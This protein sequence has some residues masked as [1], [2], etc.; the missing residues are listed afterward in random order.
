[1]HKGG[2]LVWMIAVDRLRCLRDGHDYLAVA[3][4]PIEWCPRCGKARSLSLSAS[5]R[6]RNELDEQALQLAT[7]A[8]AQAR[9]ATRVVA[10]TTQRS[11]SWWLT[12]QRRA[13]RERAALLPGNGRAIPTDPS[14]LDKLQEIRREHDRRYGARV[15]E[16]N[17]FATP[18]TYPQHDDP[19]VTQAENFAERLARNSQANTEQAR[20]MY[21]R[22]ASNRPAVDDDL[23]DLN[24]KWR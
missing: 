17:S 19:P 23:L 10:S 14:M 16:P 7:T 13:W 1:M 20:R 22:L 24:G 6:E 9:S 5:R 12:R 21:E 2:A 18:D 3:G 4:E 8:L 11:I 15:A